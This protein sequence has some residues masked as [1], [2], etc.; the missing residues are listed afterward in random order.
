MHVCHFSTPGIL[1]FV[2]NSSRKKVSLELRNCVILWYRDFLTGGKV[3]IVKI[4][5]WLV[6]PESRYVNLNHAILYLVLYILG[7]IHHMIIICGTQ[8]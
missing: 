4:E 1:K 2:F 6:Y 8:V 5:K 7:A 3:C